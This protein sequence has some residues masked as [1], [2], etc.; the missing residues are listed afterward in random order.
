MNKIEEK[1]VE[2]SNK[3]YFVP[4]FVVAINFLFFIICNKIFELRYETV[5]DFTI[6]KIISALDGHYS[7]YGVYIHPVIC[8]FIMMLYKT[9]ININWYTV[10]LLVIQFISFSAIGIVLVQRNK[11]SGIGLYL[12]LIFIYYSRLLVI[13]NYTTIAAT[14]IVAGIIVLLQYKNKKQKLFGYIL[15]IIGIMLRTKAIA[16]V[17]PFYI[18]YIIFNLIEKRNLKLNSVISIVL[19]FL[20]IYISNMVIYNFKPLNKEYTKFNKIRTYFFDSNV[21][22]Y[23]KNKEIFD[24]AG[25]SY[26]DW[27]VFYSYSLAD[28]NFYTTER[29]IKLKEKLNID[30]NYFKN[31]VIE[32]CN[33]KIPSMV[34]YYI[35]IELS[36]IILVLLSILY[37]KIEKNV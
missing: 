22:D 2:I 15:L 27:I 13:I 30:F 24:K 11:K 3:K 34:Q 31:K 23:N 18:I 6:A 9:G 16:L 5:D 25:W 21:L 19:L 4:I 26:A 20:V 36:I 10:F 29:L 12:I 14:A 7:I 32:T 33:V 1:I 28:E 8:F 37:Q 17:I 35:I